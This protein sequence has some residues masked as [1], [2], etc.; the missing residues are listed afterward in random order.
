[1]SYARHPQN[2]HHERNLKKLKEKDKDHDFLS[3]ESK[4]NV[5][6]YFNLFKRSHY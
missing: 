3:S 2:F 4:E 6:E 1:M 5:K